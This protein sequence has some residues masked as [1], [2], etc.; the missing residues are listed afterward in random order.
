M[1]NDYEK[2]QNI[3]ARAQADLVNY[4]NQV[5]NENLEIRSKAEQRIMLKFIDVID[6]FEKAIEAVE[7]ADHNKKWFKGI[8]AIYR[9]FENVLSNE[10][11]SR[12][13][14]E[15]SVFDPRLHEAIV[16]TPTDEFDSGTVIKEFSRG[17]MKKE[18]VVRPSMVEIATEKKKQPDGEI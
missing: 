17:Y 6:Q 9:N 4:R 10:G 11:F 3:A 18:N 13:E 15:G 5:Q 16:N 7:N 1:K 12:I 14:S 2:I 8:Q